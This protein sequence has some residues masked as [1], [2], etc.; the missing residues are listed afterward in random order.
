[1]TPSQLAVVQDALEEAGLN[2]D[3]I[4][5][6]ISAIDAEDLYVSVVRSESRYDDR[7]LYYPVYGADA[8]SELTGRGLRTTLE[9]EVL[10]R[11]PEGLGLSAVA[12]L[13]VVTR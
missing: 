8:L 2:Q 4:R 9:M 1:V 6:A 5:R 7:H 3:Q 12:R 10:G 11:G 13:F